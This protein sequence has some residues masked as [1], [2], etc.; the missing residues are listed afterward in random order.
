M[1]NA[2]IGF[3]SNLGDR[4]AVIRSAAARLGVTRL[5]PLYETAPMYVEDQP[6]FLNAVG[7]LQTEEGPISLLKRLKATELEVGRLPRERY[8]PR[9][10][11]LDLLAF[12]VLQLRSTFSGRSRLHVPH[13]RLVERRFVLQPLF[14]LIPDFVLP[15]L[16]VVSD[17]LPLTEEQADQVRRYGG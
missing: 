15:G 13:P 4:E 1:V 12:G 8:G 10:I 14:D 5:S 17:L 7:L 6:A 16:G 2:I 3:G 9:E 11:D